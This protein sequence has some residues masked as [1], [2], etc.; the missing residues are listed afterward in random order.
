MSC[1]AVALGP[2]IVVAGVRLSQVKRNSMSDSAER[3]ERRAV[4]PVAVISINAAAVHREIWHGGR[5]KRVGR[6]LLG[7]SVRCAP[8]RRAMRDI[9][10]DSRKAASVG[11]R[12][13]S[14]QVTRGV[15]FTHCRRPDRAEI[16]TKEAVGERPGLFGKALSMC[17]GHS[18]VAC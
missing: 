9:A 12:S 10:L 2:S 3:H 15:H 16:A 14:R 18:V 6:D 13:G 1:P 5:S 11:T 8:R 4:I 17:R 7:R